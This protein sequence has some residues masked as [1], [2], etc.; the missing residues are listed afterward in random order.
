[1]VGKNIKKYLG[2]DDYTGGMIEEVTPWAG[3]GLYVE[4]YRRLGIGPLVEETLPVKKSPKGLKHG[5]MTEAFSVLSALGGECVDDFATLRPDEGLRAILG[6]QMPA[7]ETGR[8]WLDKAHEPKLIVEAKK[9]AEQ[10]GFLSYIPA[11]SVYLR[12][13]NN[14][15]RRVVDAFVTTVKPGPQVTL[16]IDAH[17][18]GSAKQSAL[19][20]YE[21]RTGFQPMFVCWAETNLV[22]KDEF[23]N[24]NVPA[25]KDIVRML[26]E[27]YAMLPK[28]E[29]KESWVV[30]VRSDSAAYEEDI[31]DHCH[32]RGWKFG[33]SA[34]M[35]QQLRATMMAIEE[36]EWHFWREYEGGVICEWAEVPYVPSRKGEKKDVEVPIYR[37]VGIRVRHRQ[38]DLFG[39]G[40]NVRY[41][42]I[43]SN[44][45]DMEGPELLEWQ[46]GKAG[47]IEHIHH[48][49]LSELGAG[50]Y[51]S[52]KFG[53][54]AAWLRIQVLTHNL[55][56]LMKAVALP[57]EF[58]KA[59]PKRLR[60]AIFTQWGRV[61][62]HAHKMI[63][64]ITT[65][66]LEEIIGPG[67][68]RMRSLAWAGG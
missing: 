50:V 55:L 15:N 63:V 13:L 7:P 21:G 20:T 54:N 11:E 68:R 18:V 52:D 5:E 35:S 24:G 3:V 53:A 19:M 41:H 56:E 59:R 42:A 39:D 36:G 44:R 17:V 38:G 60:F 6:Y 32:K 25:E 45:W 34:D 10:L 66:A 65:R 12:G 58:R 47:T 2:I 40:E 48:V 29:G 61:V 23:R 51:P 62:R 26:D 16:D 27:A 67:R 57:A 64:R 43:V 4:L 1:M 46:R 30:F 28:R 37:Y 31:L 8:Q 14:G 49:L 33:I 22:L 9:Q